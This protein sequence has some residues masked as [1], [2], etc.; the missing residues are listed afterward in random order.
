MPTGHIRELV[1][2]FVEKLQKVLRDD[3]QT[4]IANLD[5]A[6][7]GHRPSQ[8]SNGH[9]VTRGKGSKRDPAALNA[10]SEQFVK[11]VASNP[12]LRIEQINKEL[13]TTTKDLALPI[14]KLIADGVIKTKGQKRSTTYTAGSTRKANGRKRRKM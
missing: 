1:D 5:L 11:F 2:E 9:R 6:L 12:D 4:A 7:G 10:L 8:A 3:L 13:G 14:R